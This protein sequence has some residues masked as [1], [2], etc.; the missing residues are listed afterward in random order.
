M[1][2][3]CHKRCGGSYRVLGAPPRSS[4]SRGHQRRAPQLAR[5][6]EIYGTILLQ[7]LE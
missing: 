2:G 7:P 6:A 5:G 3:V 1:S 4:F